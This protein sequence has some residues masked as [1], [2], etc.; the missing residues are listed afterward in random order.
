MAAHKTAAVA[1]AAV[2]LVRLEVMRLT[3][4]LAA[5][6][7][8]VLATP[9]TAAAQLTRAVVVVAAQVPTPGAGGAGGGGAGAQVG[10]ATAG[11]ANTGGGGGGG[12]TGG[13]G[14][15]G[16]VIIRYLTADAAAF[17]ITS[18]GATSGTPTVDGSY[19]YFEYNGSGTLVVA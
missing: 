14:G 13:A 18:T 11:T 15:S 16:K 9:T 6:A 3:Q 1:A 4:R 7:G 12:R 5:Q 8:Q 19:S 10:T 2:V 17:T